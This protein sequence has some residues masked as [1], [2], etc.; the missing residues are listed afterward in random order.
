MGRELETKAVKRFLD[1][2]RVEGKIQKPAAGK[3]LFDM[4]FDS[5]IALGG[6]V[7][8]ALTPRMMQE[9]LAEKL[10]GVDYMT[11]GAKMLKNF[12]ATSED[13]KAIRG[14]LDGWRKS[15]ASDATKYR[16]AINSLNAYYAHIL[17]R[18][19]D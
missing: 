10:L 12:R 8:I 3:K 19:A 16:K 14:I 5:G 13:L 11:T 9:E 4:R 2:A 1:Q 6:P 17:S 7:G 15:K 18:G